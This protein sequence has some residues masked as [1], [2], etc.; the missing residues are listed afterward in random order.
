MRACV[1]IELALRED[2]PNGI[3]QHLLSRHADIISGH[4]GGARSLAAKAFP[5]ARQISKWDVSH[6]QGGAAAAA[7]AAAG[8][9]GSGAG[10]G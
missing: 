1:Q 2:T 10:S 6:V 4:G 9:V 8:E 3:P 7:A 5:T